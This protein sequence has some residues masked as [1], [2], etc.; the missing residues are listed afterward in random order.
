MKRLILNY[1]LKYET[2]G[3]LG[4]WNNDTRDEFRLP[5]GRLISIDSTPFE[6]NKLFAMK[7]KPYAH[8][9]Y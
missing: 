1:V 7:C 2:E 5:D 6:I 9:N 4:Y 8:S 3:L